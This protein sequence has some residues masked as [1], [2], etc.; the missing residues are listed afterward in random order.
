MLGAGR[1][2]TSP[3]VIGREA[4]LLSLKRTPP[5]IG[6]ATWLPPLA[7]VA[8]AAS[9]ILIGRTSAVVGVI[10]IIGA[11]LAGV[12]LV[13]DEATLLALVAT[14]TLL[15]F[16][17]LPVKIG[18]SPTFLDV[19]CLVLLVRWLGRRVNPQYPPVQPTPLNG[20]LWIWL[21][22]AL[23]A[24]LAAVG[25]TPLT[26]DTMHYFAKVVLA[27]LVFFF[28]VDAV[29]TRAHLRHL[30]LAF[31]CGGAGAAAIGV[32]LYLLRPAT[33][34]RLLNLLSILSYPTGPDVLRYRVDFNLAERAI[35]TSVDPNVLGGLLML[36]IVLTLSQLVARKPFL[37]RR[38]WAL[39][40][41]PMLP[42]LL[43]T[44]SRSSWVGL[45]AAFV[46]MG[47]WRYRRLL[48]VGIILLALFAQL[49]VS[50]RFSRQLISGLEAK[51]Q[52]AAMRLG[53]ASDAL[54][55]ITTYPA[56][57]VGF[58]GSPDLNLYVGVS[59]IYLQM[60]EEVGIAGLVIFLALIAVF[61][62]WLLYRLPRI[63]DP[64]GADIV[65]GLIAATVAMVVA[66]MLDR[67]FFSFQ[68]DI[69]LMWWLLGMGAAAVRVAQSPLPVAVAERTAVPAPALRVHRLQPRPARRVGAR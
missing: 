36:S 31:C 18:L 43:M 21:G 62:L 12:I 45:F 47:V 6:P 59:N 64:P 20:L 33:S 11:V 15:P 63:H 32:L 48:V 27:T 68:S 34:T 26:A 38:W 65:F 16:A 13:S 9:G 42:C 61:F 41:V 30:Y 60:A 10:L 54:R 2:D 55:L 24:L 40:L 3:V 56:F 35:S 49:P 50:Q 14:V 8:A 19:L 37:R 17:T 5:L 46:F 57:G 7:G 39:L 29:R 23:V 67:Y 58:G 66:G 4:P 1:I 51:D 22:I 52:A 69:A 53:E 28:V 25:R 44:Y